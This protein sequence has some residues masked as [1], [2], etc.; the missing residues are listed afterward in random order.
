MY[1]WAAREET[2]ESLSN[3]AVKSVLRGVW[4]TKYNRRFVKR[5]AS[6]TLDEVHV[7][8]LHAVTMVVRDYIFE[9]PQSCPTALPFF[10][11]IDFMIFEKK[12]IFTQLSII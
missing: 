9:I 10:Q 7:Y 12:S 6:V 5:I 1:A 2:V 3:V 4:D 11:Q 8:W